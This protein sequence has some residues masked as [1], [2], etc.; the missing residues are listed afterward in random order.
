MRV[1]G[2]TR[3]STAEQGGSGLGLA[4]QEKAI[5]DDCNRRGWTLLEIRT[6]IA[7][8]TGKAARPALD[9]AMLRLR[10][11][12]AD[13]LMVA[14]VDRLS[15][16]LSELVGTM[17]ESKKRGWKL[18]IIDQGVDTTTPWGA[19]IVQMAGVF[20]ELE[21]AMIGERTKSALAAARA[22]GVILGRRKRLLSPGLC[23]AVSDAYK[24]AGTTEIANALRDLG[25]ANPW[26]GGTDWT[27][28]QVAQVLRRAGTRLRRRRAS[29]G[30]NS[31]RD[32]EKAYHAIQR[33]GL[34]L[35]ALPDGE[36]DTGDGAGTVRPAGATED[37]E[38]DTGSQ[39]GL[40]EE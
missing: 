3:V 7:T 27:P 2:Y 39:A 22:R 37:H 32:V 17:S 40:E 33:V 28:A 4:A 20:A 35:S 18:V 31:K 5:R 30:R 6:D 24:H 34:A 21:A 10:L 23:Q 9:R 29:A 11:G 13:V 19:A 12:E 8:G 15:R 26:T 25:V 16:S 14:R 36:L 38:C 1:V